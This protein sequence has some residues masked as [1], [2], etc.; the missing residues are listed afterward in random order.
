[1]KEFLKLNAKELET[2]QS[3][4]V[5]KSLDRAVVKARMDREEKV[6]EALAAVDKVS[7]ITSVVDFDKDDAA[8]WVEARNN[9]LNAHKLAEADLEIFNKNFPAEDV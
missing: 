6:D 8:K 2:L 3:E 5:I 9:A 4:T 1:M 7:N